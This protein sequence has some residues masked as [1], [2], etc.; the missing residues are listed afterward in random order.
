[1]PHSPPPRSSRRTR[2]PIPRAAPRL[3]V[4]LRLPRQVDVAAAAARGTWVVQVDPPRVLWQALRCLLLSPAWVGPCTWLLLQQQAPWF[5]PNGRDDR[6]KDGDEEDDKEDDSHAALD[7][8]MDVRH[9]TL[10][11]GRAILPVTRKHPR[12]TL[13]LLILPHWIVRLES[14]Q[15]QR[16]IHYE[17][18][19]IRAQSM[20][21]FLSTLGGG[22]FLCH[23]WRT[24]VAMAQQQQHMAR[25]LGD[26]NMYFKCL[27]HQAYNYIYAGH[28][29]HAQR[30]LLHV[31]HAVAQE[32]PSEEPV[33][34]NMVASAW[35]FGGRVQRFARQ[36]R[37]AHRRRTPLDPDTPRARTAYSKTMDD[38]GR[39]RVMKDESS[40]DDIVRA[41]H[42]KDLLAVNLS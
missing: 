7:H 23:H 25:V 14:S 24:A 33:L 37:R 8:G 9:V 3:T 17:N 6:G 20:A 35:L 22:F 32:R 36:Q 12:T 34:V 2:C 29:R 28:F 16:F 42:G 40:R 41:F 26:T 5:P 4:S 19:L 11:V 10:R 38:Y 31:R 27:I 1:M 39:I 13:S 15:E 21:G 30:L 18:Q